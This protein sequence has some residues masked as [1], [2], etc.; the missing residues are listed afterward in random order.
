MSTSNIMRNGGDRGNMEG[1]STLLNRFSINP[2][3]LHCKVISFF[4]YSIAMTIS[5]FQNVFLVS[6]GLSVAQSGFIT[7]MGF[8]ASTLT[9]PCWGALNWTMLGCTR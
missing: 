4:M 6:I 2:R 3:T 1:R 7:G 8:V 5:T 9:G